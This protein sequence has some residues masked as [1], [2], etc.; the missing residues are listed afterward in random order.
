MNNYEAER[1]IE[2]TIFQRGG[3]LVAT[4]KEQKD[5]EYYCNDSRRFCKATT[6]T[7]CYGCRFYKPGLFMQRKLL[8]EEIARLEDTRDQLIKQNTE[9]ARLAAEQLN[10]LEAMRSEER[11]Y[12]ELRMNRIADDAAIGKSIKRHKKNSKKRRR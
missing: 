2:R 3:C 1:K 7:K 5:C 11:M 6:M 10:A 12:M 4:E 9:Q 8:V